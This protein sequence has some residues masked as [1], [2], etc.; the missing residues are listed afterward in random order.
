MEVVIDYEYLSGTHGKEVIKELSVASKDVQE[1]FH[2]LPPTAWTPIVASKTESVGSME[3]L[4]I[5]RYSKPWQKSRSTLPIYTLKALT[6][7]SF[8]TRYWGALFK[9]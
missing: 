6:N 3:V 1:T 5:H 9:I 2:F 8:S 4:I 7:A